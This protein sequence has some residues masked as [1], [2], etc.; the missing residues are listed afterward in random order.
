MSTAVVGATRRRPAGTRCE[1][2]QSWDINKKII[3][4]IRKRRRVGRFSPSASDPASYRRDGSGLEETFAGPCYFLKYGASP[5]IYIS[6]RL[7]VLELNACL[8][9]SS[10]K[11]AACSKFNCASGEI[12]RPPIFARKSFSRR[13]ASLRYLVFSDRRN[14][15]PPR[16]SRA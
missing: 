6:R 15:L 4:S 1:C 8:L 12:F 3:N 7:T 2:L 11:F 10:H 14:C 5:L 9:V 13:S 16:F